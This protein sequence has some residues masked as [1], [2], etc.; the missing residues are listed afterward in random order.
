MSTGVRKLEPLTMKHPPSA[1][2]RLNYCLAQL[3]TGLEPGERGEYVFIS[4][5]TNEGTLDIN[6]RSLWC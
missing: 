4:A 2:H 5:A 1:W 3:R 6:D